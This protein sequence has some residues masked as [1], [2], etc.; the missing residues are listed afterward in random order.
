[1]IMK[2]DPIEALERYYAEVDDF[3][4]PDRGARS[5]RRARMWPEVVKLVA[6]CAAG[7]GIA[8][9]FTSGEP[10]LPQHGQPEL[11]SWALKNQVR[12]GG[13]DPDEYFDSLHGRGQGGMTAWGA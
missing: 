13:L 7:L 4:M 10:G 11:P 1:M 6:A 12:S 5:R 2:P 3:P 9:A 8:V